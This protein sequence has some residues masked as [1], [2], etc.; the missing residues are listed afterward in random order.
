MRPLKTMSA[1]LMSVSLLGASAQAASVCTT[2]AEM[3]ALRTAAVQQELMVAGLTCQ[4][5]EAYNRFVL[6]YRP[7][8]QRSDADLK[9]YF[10]RRNGARGEADYDTFKTKLANLSSLSDIADGPAYCASARVAF[11][12]ALQSHQGLD[13]FIA[14]Q[15]LLIAL[16]A[17][18]LCASDP[19]AV[20]LASV[21]PVAVAGVPRHDLPAS[22]YGGGTGA[23]SRKSAPPP[24]PAT[25]PPPQNYEDQNSDE[26]YDDT[27]DGPEAMPIPPPPP[28]PGPPPVIQAERGPVYRPAGWPP[29]WGPQPYPRW[30]GP[31]PYPYPYYYGR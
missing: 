22:P 19:A 24:A 27:D 2:P 3:A 25:Y 23:P 7:E 5:G 8:L 15:R 29:G 9:A 26:D 17:Q 10:L 6:A 16:P 1:A 28:P 4:A 18:Q 30:G 12:M 20:K 31:A 13:R 21:G 14:D 11:A